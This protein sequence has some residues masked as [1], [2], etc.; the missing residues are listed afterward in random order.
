MKIDASFVETKGNEIE[1]GKQYQYKESMP[2]MLFDI[3]ILEDL[4]N[5]KEWR[6]KYQVDK[7]LQGKSYGLRD[8]E[9]NEF[10]CNKEY[11]NVYH[12]GMFRIYDAGT[13]GNF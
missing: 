6:F 4:C 5:E 8:G 10:M 11:A 13:Y 3:T 12:G 1:V 2:N 9:E 7:V